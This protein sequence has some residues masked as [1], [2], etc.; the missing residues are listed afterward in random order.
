MAGFDA[1]CRFLPSCTIERTRAIPFHIPSGV[2]HLAPLW[3]AGSNREQVWALVAILRAFGSVYWR[4][5]GTSR[6]RSMR[7]RISSVRKR[8]FF[9]CRPLPNCVDPGP[10]MLTSPSQTHG[11]FRDVQGNQDSSLRLCGSRSALGYE[12]RRSCQRTSPGFSSSPVRARVLNGTA[13]KGT[14]RP[15]NLVCIQRGLLKRTR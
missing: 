9:C 15:N 1:W 3:A 10:C 7:R 11:A 8:E 6:R 2:S 14:N 4:A 13:R 12:S 5:F